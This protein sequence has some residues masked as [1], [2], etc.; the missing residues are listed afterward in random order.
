MRSTDRAESWQL[1]ALS[2]KRINVLTSN[3]MATFQILGN[4]WTELNHNLSNNMIYTAR[5]NAITK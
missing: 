2:V 5:S 3:G 4:F 1:S